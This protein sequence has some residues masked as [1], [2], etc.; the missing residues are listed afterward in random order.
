MAM[1]QMNLAV[2]AILLTGLLGAGAAH[3][4]IGRS[5]A[6]IQITSKASEYL[7]REGIGVWT[8]D[9]IAVQAEA[10]MTANKLTLVCSQPAQAG[11]GGQSCEEIK[12]LIAE[13]NVIYTTPDGNI[14][15]DKATYDYGADT[16][17]V[18]GN[19]ISTRGDEGVVR[20]TEM[21]YN[22]G[23]G[24]VRIT[25]GDK[26]VLSIITPKKKDP[27]AQPAPGTAPVQPAPQPAPAQPAPANRPN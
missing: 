16:I 27:A 26:R 23:E 11:E 10:K 2:S 25:A 3:A 19:V 9:V 13:G 1:K 22:V 5:D 4:Q 20:G 6:P 21:V 8:G 17:T 15:G 18:T 7:Q 14:S 24:R 12:E